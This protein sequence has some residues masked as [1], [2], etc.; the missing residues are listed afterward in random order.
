M[1]VLCGK[2]VI[3]TVY[4]RFTDRHI[5]F[6]ASEKRGLFQARGFLDNIWWLCEAVVR[7]LLLVTF[8][9]LGAGL[10]M[11]RSTAAGADAGLAAPA[12]WTKMPAVAGGAGILTL[13][14]ALPLFGLRC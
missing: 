6:F 13:L 14:L 11:A 12:G 10:A 1:F 3:A 8:A 2:S 5:D 9:M 7:V 4:N